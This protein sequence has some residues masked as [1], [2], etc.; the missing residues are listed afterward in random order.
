MYKVKPEDESQK[1]VKTKDLV[2]LYL[3]RLLSMKISILPYI[4]KLFDSILDVNGVP[5]M[6]K[7]LYDLLD[8][9]VDR[10]KLDE[11][12]LHIWKSHSY[13][14]H[15]WADF[16]TKPE[17][18]FDIDKPGYTD[19]CLEVIS[20]T[21]IDSF[22]TTSHNVNKESPTH[23]L[24]FAT[25]MD[26]YRKKVN[27]LYF[28]IR[29]ATAITAVDFQQD[30]KEL[31]K[32]QNNELAYNKISAL[33]EIFKVIDNFMDD[34]IDDLRKSP[35]ARTLRLADRLDE[36]VSIMKGSEEKTTDYD[37]PGCQ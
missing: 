37:F 35:K 23:K 19:Q 9:L 5:T 22:S 2:E 13:P 1:R 11:E 17:V 12:T 6:V 7:T 20:Q 25:E 27:N 24:L 14:I 21:F 34:V 8:D 28:D 32:E 16:I 29:S 36:I 26:E 31:N 33:Y 10:H 4:K 15:F 18:V 3:N 30:M